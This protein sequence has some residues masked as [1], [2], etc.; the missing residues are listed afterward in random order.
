MY[1]WGID[2]GMRRGM[3]GGPPPARAPRSSASRCASLRI[4]DEYLASAVDERLASL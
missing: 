4:V 2:P 3:G 1:G